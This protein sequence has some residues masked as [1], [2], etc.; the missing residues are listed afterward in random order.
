ML[1]RIAKR[2]GDR[3]NALVQN[4]SLAE[5]M[6]PPGSATQPHFHKLSEEFYF[7]L[8]GEGTME[9]DGET[10]IVAPGDA[11]L[12]NAGY[13]Y[14]AFDYYYRQPIAWRGRLVNY[15]L[16]ITHLFHPSPHRLARNDAHDL[17][18]AR[19]LPPLEIR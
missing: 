13:T 5:A 9:I 16:P 14:T 10:K 7:I 6:V 18:A 2:L 11:I 19:E 4:Q 1:W 8:E 17:R 3:T 12:I 15:Q